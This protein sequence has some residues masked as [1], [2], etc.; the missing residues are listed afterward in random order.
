M[1]RVYFFFPF[2]ETFWLKICDLKHLAKHFKCGPISPFP[3][4]FSTNSNKIEFDQLSIKLSLYPSFCSLAITFLVVFRLIRLSVLGEEIISIDNNSLS[5][6]GISDDR[7]YIILKN[8]SFCEKFISV[9]NK[10]IYLNSGRISFDR[11]YTDRI[12]VD[13]FIFLE[14][15]YLV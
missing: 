10:V 14:G 8:I 13:Q 3:S 5:Y 7:K 12:S 6:N 11:K 1:V 9:E 4:N 2:Y 15:I